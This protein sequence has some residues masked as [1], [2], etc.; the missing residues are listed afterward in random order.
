MKR[1]EYLSLHG[2]AWTSVVAYDKLVE[3]NVLRESAIQ[4]VNLLNASALQLLNVD[5]TS[6]SELDVS[7]CTLLKK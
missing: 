3:L 5:S 4:E 6:V 7:V 2:T 1:L